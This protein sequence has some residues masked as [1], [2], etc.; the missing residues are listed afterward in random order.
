VNCRVLNIC[1]IFLLFAEMCAPD[2]GSGVPPSGAVYMRPNDFKMKAINISS[3]RT[4]HA[5]FHLQEEFSP[6][7]SAL[8]KLYFEDIHAV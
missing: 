3:C 5:K 2:G 6:R 1:I 7:K 8:S 4:I